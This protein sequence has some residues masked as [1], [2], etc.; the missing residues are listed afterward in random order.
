MRN[1]IKWSKQVV[2]LATIEYTYKERN[3]GRY[4]RKHTDSPFEHFESDAKRI[5][6]S[7]LPRDLE[8]IYGL[9]V[10]TE[11][12]DVQSGSL[13]LFFGAV[14]SGLTVFS[15]YAGF[16]DSVNLVKQHSKL[17]LERLTRNYPEEFEVTVVEQFPTLRD[18]SDMGFRRL[19]KMLGPEFDNVW[20]A[21]GFTNYQRS[22]RDAFFWY[23]LVFNI[24]LLAGLGFLVSGAV[25]KT[26]FR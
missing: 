4:L 24:L 23:L 13:L 11:I 3:Q 19:R 10:E 9:R 22:H 15:S 17:L 7:D 26:Y 8:R 21:S 1:R 25:L 20:A 14:I 6:E 2:M 16:F 12:L 5:V 18:P